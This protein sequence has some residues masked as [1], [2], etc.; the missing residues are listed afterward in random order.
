MNFSK[1]TPQTLF[2]FRFSSFLTYQNLNYKI[3]ATP[4]LTHFDD[5]VI[6]EYYIFF[7]KKERFFSQRD[8]H[9]ILSF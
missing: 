4:F 9:K 2:Y 3:L 5:L 8:F 7:K 1:L 6:K